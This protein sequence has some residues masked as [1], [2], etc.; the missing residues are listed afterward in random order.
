M[1][2]LESYLCG[3]ENNPAACEDAIFFGEHLVA[4]IDGVTAKGTRLW[5]G[6]KSGYYA[7]E[8]LCS[9][10]GQKGVEHQ[11]AEALFAN[12]DNVLSKS[13]EVPDLLPPE[14]YPR[15][16][17]IIYNDIYKEVWSYGD[18]QCSINGVVHTHAKK[19]TC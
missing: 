6:H 7:K 18:C 12:L 15:A 8:I 19:L 17:V 2:I 10:L 14:E 13:V 16:S 4:V 3:K 1:Q 11:T 9:Y 5:S